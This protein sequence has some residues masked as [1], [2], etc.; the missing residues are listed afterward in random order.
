MA[1]TDL[2]N[3]NNAARPRLQIDAADLPPTGGAVTPAPPVPTPPSLWARTPSAPTATPTSHAVPAVVAPA[4]AKGTVLAPAHCSNCRSV[5][6]PRAVACPG[7]G[8]PTQAAYAGQLATAAIGVNRKSSGV[9]LLLSLLWPGAGQ[10]YVGKTEAGAGFMV[11]SFV[12]MILMFAV[13]GLIVYPAV[14]IWAMVDAYRPAEEHNRRLLQAGMA[15]LVA[16][17]PRAY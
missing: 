9:A 10:I 11:G 8:L 2:P 6:D 7:C 13:I 16:A 3:L 5:M 17:P 15:G 1:D 12:A 4:A 14:L